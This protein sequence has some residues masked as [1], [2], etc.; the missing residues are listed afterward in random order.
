ML[1]PP[2]TAL[3]TY[4]ISD[5]YGNYEPPLGAAPH[6]QISTKFSTICLLTRVMS[7]T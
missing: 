6:P 2:G 1:P 3:P 4:N 7:I 5:I